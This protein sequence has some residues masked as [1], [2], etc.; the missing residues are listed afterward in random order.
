TNDPV[1]YNAITN[2]PLPYSIKWYR[3]NILTYTGNTSFWND[4]II[5]GNNS[6]YAVLS[7]PTQCLLPDSVI[8]NSIKVS[9]VTSVSSF[10]P[11]GFSIY[12]NPTESKLMI[13]GLNINDEYKIFDGLGNIIRS[14][15]A[16]KTSITL[17]V[18]EL[19]NG[20]YQI[21]FMRSAKTWTTQFLKQ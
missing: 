8:S 1:S 5:A 10:I 6:V 17:D 9:N 3:N 14:G 18:S 7:S 2:I 12:P 13:E 16:N 20:V 15:K 11:E 19:A 4:F 21:Y